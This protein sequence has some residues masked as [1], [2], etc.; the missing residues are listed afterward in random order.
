[1]SSTPKLPLGRRRFLKGAATGAA[2]LVAKAAPAVRPSRRRRGAA[3]GDSPTRSS[4]PTPNPRAAPPP[5]FIENPASD[6]MVDVHQDAGLRV[7][8]RQ[9]RIELRG[10]ARVDHQ[11]RREQGAG[12]ADLL[13]RGVVGR[14]GARLR[15]DR[16]QADAGARCTATSASSTRRWRSTTPTPIACPSSSSSATRIDGGTAQRRE[17]VPQRAGHGGD[18]PRLREVGRRAGLAGAVRR[19]GGPRLQDCDDPADGAGAARR[20]ITTHAGAPLPAAVPRIPRL[21]MP[22]PPAGDIG[23]GARSG[24]A[25]GRGREPADH[26]RPCGADAERH[27]AARRARRAAAGAGQRRRRSVNFPS[28]HPLAGNGIRASRMSSSTSRCRA[29]RAGRWRGNAHADAKPISISA[30]DLPHQ[31]QLPGL[32]AHGGGRPRRSRPTPKPRCR[33]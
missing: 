16:R 2:A 9:P 10:A 22:S 3:T 12:A 23:C 26:R 14:H 8:R 28:R 1:M 19:I 32:P 27:H 33:C 6:Y 21:T 29:W 13:S 5:A 15:Q 31:E 4:A 18:G 17:L 30:R 11:L 7:R 24:P 25:A 20:S